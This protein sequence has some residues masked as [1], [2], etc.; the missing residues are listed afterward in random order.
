MLPLSSKSL[1]TTYYLNSEIV[2]VYS[3]GSG[4]EDYH[5]QLISVQYKKKKEN[6]SLLDKS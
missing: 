4:T 2:C 6:Y 3:N 5:N 1:D